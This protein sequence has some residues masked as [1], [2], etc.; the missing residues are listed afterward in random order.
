MNTEALKK[1]ILP[2][3]PYLFFVYLFDKA[4]QAYGLAP[5]IDF[6]G[7]FLS[8][9]I[10]FAAAFANAAPSFAL[11]D[12]AAGIAGAALIRLIIYIKGKNAKKYRKG[13][14]Y[15]SARWVA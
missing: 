8:L 11:I 4:M 9:R 3:L 1:W 14:E 2:N 13:I 15:G 10:G 12:L 7:K 6:S 5:G